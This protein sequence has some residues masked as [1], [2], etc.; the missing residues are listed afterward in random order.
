MVDVSVL[1]TADYLNNCVD[2]TNVAK[3]LIAESLALTGSL[4]QARDIDEFDRCRNDLLGFRERGELFQ[5]FVGH[6]DD[7][8]RARPH[9]L[10]P[11][12]AAHA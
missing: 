4:H 9:R 8:L 5:T 10:R 3:K 1:K 11:G 2:L 7:A 12:V 6:A